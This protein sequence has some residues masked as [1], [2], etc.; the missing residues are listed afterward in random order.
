M[1]LISSN[2]MSSCALLLRKTVQKVNNG[3][4]REEATIALVASKYVLA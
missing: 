2:I 1:I 3:G 4:F